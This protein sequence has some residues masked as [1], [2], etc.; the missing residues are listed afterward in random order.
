MT[1]EPEPTVA[2][3]GSYNHALTMTVAAIPNPGETVLG[4]SFD[5]G[6]GGKG[7]NQAIAADR[8]GGQDDVHRS[9]RDNRSADAAFELWAEHDVRIVV[10]RETDDHAGVGF[11]MVAPD[12]ENAIA[13]APGA[14]QQLDGAVV[15]EQADAI[16]GAGV[17]LSQLEIDD[18]PVL[19]TGEV[20]PDRDTVIVL[21]PAPAREL[22]PRVYELAD[23]IT[24]NEAEARVL[25]GADGDVE[26]AA[27]AARIRDRGAGNVILTLGGDRA[28]VLTDDGRTHIEPVTVDIVD[29][30]GAGDAF[31]AGLA[32]ALAEGCEPI[33]PPARFAARAGAAACTA[34][35][36]VPALPTRAALP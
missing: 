29:T 1:T 20:A 13:V 5:E 26:P 9:G 28:L 24:P 18:E 35:E 32:V 6:V 4:A 7:S 30:T 10:E 34:Y 31:N 8:L 36:V 12:A 14:N 21:H 22:P 17:V 19:A 25:G 3:V 11:V 23:V 2:V 33:P 16:G 27:L 15:R